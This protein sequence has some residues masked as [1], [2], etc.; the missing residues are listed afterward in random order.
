M[1]RTITLLAML[2]ASVSSW[3]QEN[4]KAGWNTYKTGMIIHEYTYNFSATDSFKLYITDSATILVSSDSGVVVA[5]SYPLREKY[6]NKTINYFNPKKQVIKTE[7]YRGDNLL[8]SREWKYDEKNRKN[9]YYEDN[10][11]SGKN[12]KKN[13]EYAT[14]KKNGDI[15]ITESSYYNGRVEFYTKSYYDKNSVKYKEVR[16][17]DNNKDIIHIESYTYGENGKVKERSVFFPEFKVTKKFVEPDADDPPTCTKI[18]SL[19]TAEKVYPPGKAIY[20]RNFLKKIQS[21]LSN[22]ECPGYKY[23]YSNALNEIL[24]NST[25][26][27][28][29]G[30]LIFRYKERMP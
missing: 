15:I 28:N 21:L 11:V 16:L 18:M 29:G 30:Q 2:I 8:M 19:G 1:K 3:S 14:D 12:Y 26:A 20:L 27:S 7:D 5:V 17:N 13:Y 24:I 10:K 25:K 23:K 6:F 9:Y 4:F 22:P